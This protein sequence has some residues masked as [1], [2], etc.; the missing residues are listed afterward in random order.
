MATFKKNQLLKLIH[1][2]EASHWARVSE[3]SKDVSA[4]NKKYV[5]FFQQ[6]QGGEDAGRKL[7]QVVQSEISESDK[8]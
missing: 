5:Q 6:S 4:T 8:R 1:T 3:E 7:Y 2:A